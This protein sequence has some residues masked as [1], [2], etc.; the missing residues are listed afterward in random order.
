MPKNFVEGGGASSVLAIADYANTPLAPT[1][2]EL[3]PLQRM[4]VIKEAERQHD[5]AQ[6]S[7][8]S[9]GG[10]RNPRAGG[11]MSKQGETVTYVNNG[12]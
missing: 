1:Q 2:K 5:E 7:G 6:G 12:S 11:G 9:T 10:Q 4:V 8:A 3:T